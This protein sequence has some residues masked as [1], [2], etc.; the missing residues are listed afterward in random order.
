M[1]SQ[2]LNVLLQALVVKSHDLLQED[3]V[4]AIYNMAAVDFSMFYKT[5]VSDFLK[6]VNTIDYHQ[7]QT[8]N[9]NLN[10]EHCVSINY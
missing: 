3:I 7:K 2:F 8:L 6:Q 1:M 5:F 10:P 4:A 9:D